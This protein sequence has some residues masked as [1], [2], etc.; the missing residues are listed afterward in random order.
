MYIFAVP[1]SVL[2]RSAPSGR[3]L[4]AV[5]GVSAAALML[6]G[7]AAY[8]ALRD[9]VGSRPPEGFEALRARSVYVTSA[10]CEPCHAD[11]VKSWRRT[12]HSTMTREA[13]STA[14]VAPFEGRP[15]DALG[16]R[17]IP[18]RRGDAYFIDTLDPRTGAVVSNRIARVT[19]S[20]R[21]QQFETRIDDRYVRLPIAWSIEERRWLHLSEAFF[22]PDGEG[23]DEPRAVWDLNCIFCHTVKARPGLDARDRV[24]SR[25]AELGVACEACHGPGEEHARRMRSPLR[26]YGFHVSGV[27]DPAIVN[28]RRIDRMR[29]AQICG[30]CHGQRLPADRDRIR[31][32]FHDGDPYTAGEDLGRYFVPIDRETSIAG[33]SFASRFWGDGSPRLTAYEYQGMIRSACFRKGTM[34]CLSCHAM[35]TGDP[36]GQMRPDLPGDAVC[37]QCHPAYGGAGN[38]GHTKHAAS[39]AGSRCVACH[40]PP[41]VYGIMTWHPT[42]LIASPDPQ[43]AAASGTPDACTLCHTGRSIA[44][45]AQK[46]RTLWPRNGRAGT[47]PSEARFEEPEIERALFAGDV[48]MRTLAVARLAGPSPEGE[49]AQRVAPLVAELLTDRY[50]AVRRTAR[51]TLQ[52]L[53]GRRDLPGANDAIEARD[54]ARRA[55]QGM[56]RVAVIPAGW[57]YLPDGGLDRR[58]LEEWTHERKEAPVSIGE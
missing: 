18:W 30:H 8:T 36:H 47:G 7:W 16:V 24:D 26:R 49:P 11:H 13:S 21:M 52:R 53:T 50:P 46:I 48:V 2:P 58:K 14:I 23:Y 51:D 9:P 45:A 20:R 43:H 4:A 1:M 38:A 33:F 10:T 54:A 25:S 28:P 40:M 6:T 15:V 22:H 27:Q 35:H 39:S 17:S 31:D 57:P 12:F 19:G 44:W 55:V 5:A 29:S 32:I 37:T 41:V 3:R 42:H 56:A 34:T